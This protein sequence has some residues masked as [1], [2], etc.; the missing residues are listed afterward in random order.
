MEKPRQPK[1]RDPLS[2][3]ADLPT[4]GTLRGVVTVVQEDRFR[5]QDADGRGY[6]FTLGKRAAV[7]ARDLHGWSAGQVPVTVAYQG[8]PDL[9]AVALTVRP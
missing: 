4:S 3:R 8:T 9:G 2:R 1:R 6:L 7:S 5:L